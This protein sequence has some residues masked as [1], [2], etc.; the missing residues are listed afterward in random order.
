MKRLRSLFSAFVLTA[1]VFG[2]I[3][4]EPACGCVFPESPLK[5]DWKLAKITYA[6]TQKTV[7]PQEAGYTE[8]ISFLGDYGSGNFKLV[9]NGIPVQTSEFSINFPN[10]GNSEGIIYF[11]IDTTQQSFRLA[12]NK[13]FLAE[14]T[15]L[16]VVIADGSTYEYNR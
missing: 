5:G 6:L 16:N 3:K 7:T 15:R 8:T 12:D 1:L 14:R 9:R 11:R 2:C 4:E 10:G 13:L